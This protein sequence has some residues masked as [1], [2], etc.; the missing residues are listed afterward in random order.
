M[1]PFT[2]L[3]MRSSQGLSVDHLRKV[4]AKTTS[5]PGHRVVL[6]GFEISNAQRELL[7]E[8]SGSGLLALLASNRVPKG[9]EH[10][11]DARIAVDRALRPAGERPCR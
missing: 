11:F 2:P 1:G 5:P 6:L 3:D 8:L 7:E 9:L 4:M 10:I